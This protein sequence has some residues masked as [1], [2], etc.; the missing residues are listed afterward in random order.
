[1]LNHTKTC[2]ACC[3]CVNVRSPPVLK[4]TTLPTYAILPAFFPLSCPGQLPQ[5]ETKQDLKE[6]AKQEAKEVPKQGTKQWCCVLLTRAVSPRLYVQR[7]TCITGTSDLKAVEK[8]KVNN[9]WWREE[10]RGKCDYSQAMIFFCNVHEL[11][12]KEALGWKPPC[13]CVNTRAAS[14]IVVILVCPRYCYTCLARYI[15]VYH[16]NQLNL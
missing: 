13:C 14:K 4:G 1:M 12:V 7:P 11:L 6:A 3:F 9:H 10:G 2:H 8:R 15:K 16:K 5:Q